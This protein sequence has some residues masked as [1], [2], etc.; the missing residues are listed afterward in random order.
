MQRPTERWWPTINLYL[1]T[2]GQNVCRPVYPR[3]GDCA[4]ARICPQIGVTKRGRTPFSIRRRRKGT[5]PCHDRDA[6]PHAN[7]AGGGRVRVRL[8]IGGIRPAQDQSAP[9]IV[10]ETSRGTFAFETYPDEA[11]K[12]VA[13]IVDL[14]K[15]GFY[16]G[17]RFHRA[18]PGFRRAVGRPAVA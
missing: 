6:G 10:V 8:R 15:R 1:V 2:W 13:H 3:C 4:L 9:V 17:Q 16:D 14:V 7:L 12:T 5:A 18:V 11:P